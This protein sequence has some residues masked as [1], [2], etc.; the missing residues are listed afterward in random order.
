MSTMSIED[1]VGRSLL[2]IR[3][4]H[5]ITQSQIAHAIQARGLKFAESRVR[6]LEQ[7]KRGVSVALLV[8]LADVLSEI[9]G[10][11]TR[12]IDLF[13]AT[14]NIE[15]ASD[16]VIS[17]SALERVFSGKPVDFV[18]GD[19]SPEM[20][21]EARDIVA[22]SMKVMRDIAKDI[23]SNATNG[24]LRN[25]NP[26]YAEERAAKRLDT[27]PNAV[28]F[29]ARRL[30]KKSLDEQAMLMAGKDSSPQARGHATRK[31]E[32]E[33]KTSI[34]LLQDDEAN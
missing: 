1:A 26:T 7:G 19:L 34:T 10:E 30:W 6:E 32:K 31:L 16:L 28:A 22:Q 33:I 9:T 15:V 3:K 8:V 27:H 13:A 17:H 25:L 23:P 14:Q 11:P 18:V 5:G 21:Q 20:Q 24:E 12:L 29:W 4:K 2:E